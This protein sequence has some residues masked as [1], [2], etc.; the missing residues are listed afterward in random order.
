M[1]GLNSKELLIKKQWTKVLP[2]LRPREK[3][4][5]AMRLGKWDDNEYPLNAVGKRF[6]ITKQRTEQIISSA[7][8]RIK[9]HMDNSQISLCCEAGV[10]PCG[11]RT[12]C[13]KCF[14]NL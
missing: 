13:G 3:L 8:I 14:K 7:Y 5:L 10:E 6:G 2:L 1:Q 9:N 4:L 11:N 12:I